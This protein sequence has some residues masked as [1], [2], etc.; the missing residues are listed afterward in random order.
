MIRRDINLY[1]RYNK[2]I[3]AKAVGGAKLTKGGIIM[4]VIAAILVLAMGAAITFLLI[5]N[6]NIQKDIDK[7][8]Q[9]LNS[10]QADKDTL[11][12]AMAAI[13][14]LDKEVSGS[15]SGIIDFIKN[16]PKA[17]PKVINAILERTYDFSTET[18]YIII[19]NLTYKVDVDTNEGK[20]DLQVTANGLKGEDR[21]VVLQSFLDYVEDLEKDIKY[22]NSENVEVVLGHLEVDTTKILVDGV[23]GKMSMK[24]IT[25]PVAEGGN[26]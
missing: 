13:A 8:N 4:I 19:D 23:Q 26:E 18:D 25:E 17:N 10:T 1:A 7:A 12:E 15:T 6:G 5:S 9:Y 21:D 11:D 2:P 24:F 22:I 14:A 16:N 20:F 3:G